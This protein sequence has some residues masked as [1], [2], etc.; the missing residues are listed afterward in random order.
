[1]APSIQS[2]PNEAI[3]NVTL[4]LPADAYLALRLTC[5]DIKSRLL[6]RTDE[7]GMAELLRIERWRCYDTV[8]GTTLAVTALKDYFACHCCLKIRKALKFADS[9]LK[10]SYGK[11]NALSTKPK[12]ASRKCL[13]CGVKDNQYPLS[14][15]IPFGC[16]QGG[17]GFFCAGC[18]TFVPGPR[19]WI[20]CEGFEA[21]ML[22][23]AACSLRPLTSTYF[24]TFRVY[25]PQHGILRG[26][27]SREPEG[28]QRQLEAM[29]AWESKFAGDSDAT[30]TAK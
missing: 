15:M 13:E 18:R 6:P 5:R 12:A 4:R 8:G 23:C 2:L 24:Q 28:H 20:L 14:R 17:R 7:W 26:L 10:A 27:G 21:R 30:R 25:T 22:F 9:M 3:H 1:M 16:F 19:D 11:R 29:S